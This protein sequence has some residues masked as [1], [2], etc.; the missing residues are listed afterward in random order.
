M[1]SRS[2]TYAG[3]IA[4]VD[5]TK[6]RARPDL[7][8]AQQVFGPRV[9]GIGHLVVLVKRGDMPGNVCRNSGEKFRQPLQFVVGVVE[10]GNEQRNDLQPEAHRVQAADGVEDR[11][12]APPSSR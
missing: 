1:S 3:K 2:P 7:G 6:A 4:G 8:G 10:A 9:A 12:Q 11:L 5:V